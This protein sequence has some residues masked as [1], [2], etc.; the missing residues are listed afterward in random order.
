MSEWRICLSS[1]KW[2]LLPQWKQQRRAPKLRWG[3]YRRSPPAASG[4]VADNGERRMAVDGEVRD[5]GEKI[6]VWISSLHAYFESFLICGRVICKIMFVLTL[7]QLI[8]DG[9]SNKT[10]SR[11]VYDPGAG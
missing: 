7:H 2:M 9:G 1:A 3:D 10:E 8:R 4:A 5:G 6:S 11:E